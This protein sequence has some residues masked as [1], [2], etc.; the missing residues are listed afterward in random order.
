MS[1]P[2]IT[3]ITEGEPEDIPLTVTSGPAQPIEPP[4][5]EREPTGYVMLAATV[6]LGPG[7]EKAEAWKVHGDTILAKSADAA[8]RIAA[9]GLSEQE[10]KAGQTLVAVPARSWKPVPVKTKTETTLVIGDE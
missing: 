2:L 3:H 9:A 1:D 10:L 8:V 4:K 7:D 6:L 5:P